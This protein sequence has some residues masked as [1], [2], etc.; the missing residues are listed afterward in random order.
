MYIRPG[1]ILSKSSTYNNQPLKMKPTQKGMRRILVSQYSKREVNIV[2][3]YLD[4]FGYFG[5]LIF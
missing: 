5:Q 1:R 3:A 2:L 4:G